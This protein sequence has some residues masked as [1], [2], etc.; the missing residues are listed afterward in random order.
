[1]TLSDVTKFRSAILFGLAAGLVLGLYT[2]YAVSVLN[3]KQ[4]VMTHSASSAGRI[5]VTGAQRINIEPQ[6]V[7]VVTLR[8]MQTHREYLIVVGGQVIP[9]EE[10]VLLKGNPR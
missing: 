7:S 9:L 5:Q 8:D 4:S 6:P 10:T 1:M 3:A 2:G